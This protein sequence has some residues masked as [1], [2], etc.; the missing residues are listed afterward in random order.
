MFLVD[1]A[2]GACVLTDTLVT[3]ATGTPNQF[4]TKCRLIPH[5][6]MAM[7]GTGSG[8]LLNAWASR[9][10]DG[11]MAVDVD[12]VASHA[13]VPL[14][15]LWK[16]ICEEHG[17]DVTSTEDGAGSTATIYHFG[18][19]SKGAFVWYVFRSTSAFKPE[20]WDQGGFAVKP[21][22][23]EPLDALTGTPETV[24]AMVELA[25]QIRSEQDQQSRVERISIGGELWLTS[26]QPNSFGQARVHRFDDWLD[27]WNEMNLRLS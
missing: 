3:D 9:L 10:V 27:H 19:D 12:M 5:M 16:E 4:T 23:A 17:L 13:Q 14:T 26:L 20:R 24:D 7:A 22:P 18:Q 8:N 1:P 11:M 25:I 2:G 15:E 21:H 6:N